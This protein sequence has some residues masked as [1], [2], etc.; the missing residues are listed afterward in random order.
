MIVCQLKCARV[1]NEEPVMNYYNSGY[2]G[3]KFM[4]EY[5]SIFLIHSI[6]KF[7]YFYIMSYITKYIIC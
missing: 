4:H 3:I 1:F 7:L 6:S 5:S 2:K